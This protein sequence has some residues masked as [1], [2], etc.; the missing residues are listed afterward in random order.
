M[1]GEQAIDALRELADELNIR[2]ARKLVAA[3]RR[4]EFRDVTEPLARQA[5]RKDVARQVLAPPPRSTGKSAAEGPDKRFQ[6]DLLDF[7]KNARV[8]SGAKFALLL[9][10]VYSR[11]AATRV[12]QTKRP[13]E[14]G[15]AVE[16]GLQELAGTEQGVVITTDA[17]K[18]FAG[19]EGYLD[20]REAIIKQKRPEDL[21]AL[22]V[23]DKL[24]QTLKKDLAGV[25][26]KRGG[27]WDKNLA[28]VTNA[29]NERPHE[30]VFG[31]PDTVE[32]DKVQ[33]FLV[34]KDNAK[35]FMVNRAQSERRMADVKET[36]AVRVPTGAARS[37]E[38][39]YG[40]VQRVRKVE[41]DLVTLTNGRQ[42]LLKN[43]QAVPADSGRLQGRLTDPS[44]VRR[45]KLQPEADR[46]QAYIVE[47]GGQ[48]RA[49]DL[50]AT[51][52]NGQ[53]LPGIWLTLRRAKLTLNGFLRIFGNMFRVARGIVTL[54]N[55]PEPPPAPEPP[56]P[57]PP[58]PPP[59]PEPRQ[60]TLDERLRAAEARREAARLERERKSRERLRGLS[61]AYGSRAGQG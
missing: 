1:A 49:R 42:V 54:I 20:E 50:E 5:L 56:A 2:D 12:L 48:I 59:A 23:I 28:G 53:G 7:S 57:D 34:L 32:T 44:L 27:D 6:A 8:Q 13:E 11:E 25:A 52:R 26:A 45:T 15:P 17:G 21:Q 43:V 4:R 22:G 55:A 35:K 24:S 60:P 47:N 40:Q 29:Y 10:D 30:A 16:S 18:E 37:F 3:A 39:R 51:M 9:T 19:L 14:V 58:A 46:V 41:S 31:P 36:R 61:A 33:E 38:P